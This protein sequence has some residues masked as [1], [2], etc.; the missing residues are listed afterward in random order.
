MP[1]IH[2]ILE[3]LEDEELGEPL[4]SE[5]GDFPDDEDFTVDEVLSINTIHSMPAG[6]S[7]YLQVSSP[8]LRVL[9][10]IREQLSKGSSPVDLSTKSKPSNLKLGTPESDGSAFLPPCG[11]ST[12][13]QPIILPPIPPPPTK[14]SLSAT[15]A[16][17]V[18]KG[19]FSHRF[20]R[21]PAATIRNAASLEFP[22][23]EI[24]APTPAFQQLQ[25]NISNSPIDIFGSTMSTPTTPASWTSTGGILI[26]VGD[27]SKEFE[28]NT[29]VLRRMKSEDSVND[30]DGGMMLQLDKS[31]SF[32]G[33]SP[34]VLPLGMQPTW[35]KVRASSA[36]GTTTPSSNFIGSPLSGGGSGKSFGASLRKRR[37]SQQSMMPSPLNRRLR[38]TLFACVCCELQSN[39]FLCESAIIIIVSC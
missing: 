3:D 21:R 15:S 29:P 31:S 37:F 13:R 8:S 9:A 32:A 23:T 4:D 18:S 17:G 30:N 7:H 2:Q 28:L 26:G 5:Y 24:K 19:A 12:A 1:E 6:E 14:S 22:S 27:G 36:F 10:P 34:R 16:A 25:H 39:R 33:T 38:K 11:G 35:H 20:L